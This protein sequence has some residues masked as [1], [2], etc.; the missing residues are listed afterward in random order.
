MS[1][2]GFLTTYMKLFIVKLLQRYGVDFGFEKKELV[3]GEKDFDFEWDCIPVIP[4]DG[5]D[6]IDI[7]GYVEKHG[8]NDIGVYLTFINRRV[9]NFIDK[10]ISILSDREFIIDW[11]TELIDNRSMRMAKVQGFG[12][13]ELVVNDILCN[14]VEKSNNES[15]GMYVMYEKYDLEMLSLTKVVLEQVSVWSN[16]V[17][18]TTSTT[19][20]QTLYDDLNGVYS[21]NIFNKYDKIL[22]SVFS[23]V[24]IHLVDGTLKLEDIPENLLKDFEYYMFQNEPN[25]SEFSATSHVLYLEDNIGRDTSFSLE[26]LKYLD[27]S[28]E[29]ICVYLR[30]LLPIIKETQF[31]SLYSGLTNEF[32]RVFCEMLQEQKEP[33][34]LKNRRR[35][36]YLHG[37]NTFEK[38]LTVTCSE[39][40]K[41]SHSFCDEDSYAGLGKTEIYVDFFQNVFNIMYNSGYSSVSVLKCL[42]FISELR[43]DVDTSVCFNFEIDLLGYVEKISWQDLPWYFQMCIDYHSLLQEIATYKSIFTEEHVVSLRRLAGCE[44]NERKMEQIAISFIRLNVGAYDRETYVFIRSMLGYDMCDEEIIESIENEVQEYLCLELNPIGMIML[45]FKTFHKTK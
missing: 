12:F 38:A 36:K 19:S 4:L 41:Y 29:L 23:S 28:Y 43:F 8:S 42:K 37:V 30:L 25:I 2:Y 45:L 16:V 6:E 11:L 40:A 35:A 14:F 22:G 5:K 31:T 17:S 18:V 27:T 32:L 34:E 15:G 21:G 39:T 33:F 3:K 13:C 24:F 26:F 7:A 20:L 9:F 1:K 10:K 44:I